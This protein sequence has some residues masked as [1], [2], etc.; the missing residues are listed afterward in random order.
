MHR[1]YLLIILVHDF[2][3]FHADCT[4]SATTTCLTIQT[5]AREPLHARMQNSGLTTPDQSLVLDIGSSRPSS[6]S[7]ESDEYL[8][9]DYTHLS[10]SVSLPLHQQNSARPMSGVQVNADASGSRRRGAPAPYTSYAPT[11]AASERDYLQDD[12]DANYPGENKAYK[13][14]RAGQNVPSIYGTASRAMDADDKWNKLIPEHMAG[15]RRL[16]SN[17]TYKTARP[18]VL[19]VVRCQRIHRIYCS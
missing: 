10:A 17:G 7:V 8:N 5:R 1:V 12:F 16:A 11:T 9:G 6:P 4:V 18:G 13:P 15:K 19:G 14:E 2:V 3:R